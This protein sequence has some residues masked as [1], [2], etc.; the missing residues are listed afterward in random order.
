MTA[1]Y[2]SGAALLIASVV[3]GCHAAGS[4]SPP[5]PLV[6]ADSVVLQLDGKAFQAGCAN[7]SSGGGFRSGATC[8]SAGTGAG[9]MFESLECDPSK[10]PGSQQPPFYYVGALFRN[11]DPSGTTSDVTFDLSDPSHEQF[12]TVMMGYT[13][14]TNTQYKYCT[15]APRDT[16]PQQYPASSGLVTLHRLVPDPGAPQ[17][18]DISDA[19]LTNA[20][21]PSFNGGPPITIVAA[22]LYFQ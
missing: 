9:P 22:H 13:D 14:E 7:G 12:V 16:D 20:V 19:E 5:P 18:V 3:A 8:G 21:V 4:S 17:G 2:S 11:L 1:V 10:P 6:P 15:A